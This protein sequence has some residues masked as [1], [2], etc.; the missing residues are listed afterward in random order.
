[1]K[2]RDLFRL[3]STWQYEKKETENRNSEYM[4]VWVGSFILCTVWQIFLLHTVFGTAQIRHSFLTIAEGMLFGGIAAIASYTFGDTM[5]QKQSVVMNVS[6][7]TGKKVSI[8][9]LGGLLLLLPLH[10]ASFL[11]ILAGNSFFHILESGFWYYFSS[12]GG[13]LFSFFSMVPGYFVKGESYRLGHRGLFFVCPLLL[14]EIVMHG[15]MNSGR[16]VAGL[17]TAGI[18]LAGS[19]LLAIFWSRWLDRP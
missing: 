13:T 4:A 6:L 10:L 17:V 14:T 16:E 3:F 18:L 19:A 11:L 8:V 1:M 7:T 15:S 2:I 12:L 9:I 5:T